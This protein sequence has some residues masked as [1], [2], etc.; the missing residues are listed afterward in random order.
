MPRLKPLRDKVLIRPIDPEA[1]S[2]G[3]IVLPDVAKEARSIGKVL[4]R[5]RD[6]EEVALD[7]TVVFSNFAGQEVHYPNESGK[8]ERLIVVREE[9]IHLIEEE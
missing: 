3:G 1:V 5:G 2:K 8:E 4:A 7:D 6:V 9:D